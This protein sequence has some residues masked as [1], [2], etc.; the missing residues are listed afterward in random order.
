MRRWIRNA[1]FLLVVGAALGN[2]GLLGSDLYRLLSFLGFLVFI[3]TF[4]PGLTA[5]RKTEL[6]DA[7]YAGASVLRAAA[8]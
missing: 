4:L 2:L 7:V 8:G 3:S 1:S 5:V 6:F